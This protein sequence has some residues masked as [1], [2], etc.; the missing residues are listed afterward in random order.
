MSER[1]GPWKI[2]NYGTY[3]GQLVEDVIEKDPMFF[4]TC[5]KNYLNVSPKQSQKFYELIGTEIPDS[6]IDYSY[7]E[8][9]KV[10]RLWPYDIEPNY[11]F[12]NE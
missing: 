4:A 2:F 9:T 8:S 10:P 3:K 1:K 11:N 7:V 12:D 5:V 6:F